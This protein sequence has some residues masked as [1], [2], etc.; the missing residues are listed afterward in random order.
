[1]RKCITIFALSIILLFSLYGCGSKDTAVDDEEEIE[2]VDGDDAE[3]ME[4]ENNE[5]VSGTYTPESNAFEI[6]LP[7]GNWKIDREEEGMVS[8]QSEDGQSYFE[9]AYLSEQDAEGALGET[10]S[11]K[12]ELEEQLSYGEVVPTVESFDTKTEDG[13]EQTVYTLKYEEGDYPYMIQG[14]YVKDG[15]Y[16]T[17]IA[18]TRQDDTSVLKSLQQAMIQFKILS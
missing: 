6:L 18:M 7:D 16:F 5:V 8:L 13:V 3:E 10:P 17:V 12:E 4:E 2:Q 1:M 11:S 14:S 15:E 9:I